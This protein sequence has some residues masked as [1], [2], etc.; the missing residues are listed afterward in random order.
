MIYESIADVVGR[1]PLVRLSR[2]FT[3]SEVEV[4]AKLEFLNPLGS[5]K[6][7]VARYVLQ[8]L[9][10]RGMMLPGGRVVES[11]SG[12][13][14]I[15][16][17]AIGPLF[18]LSITCVVDP[19]IS[20]SNLVILRRLGA[21][22]EMVVE[23]DRHGGYLETRL[24]RVQGIVAEDPKA[25]WINQYANELC[26]KAHVDGIAAELVDQLDRPA[27]VLVGPVSTT[28]TLLG[29]ARGLRARWPELRVVAVDAEGSAVFGGRSQPRRLPG[30][31]ASR[32]SELLLPGEVDEVCRIGE[33]AAIQGCLDLLGSEGILAGASSGAVVSAL[34]TLIPRLPSGS[35]VVTL[36]PDRGERYIDLVFGGSEETEHGGDYGS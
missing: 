20:R 2:L 23:P 21:E 25:L 4:I 7:R 22:V 5:S 18:G 34:R 28:A 8:N 36:L 32:P 11:T 35:C 13:F 9:V 24:A 3:E 6:D 15:A 17:A 33:P 27:D 19:H 10:A 26:W 1:T 31:G 29:T 14:G 30:L 16:L 12:N